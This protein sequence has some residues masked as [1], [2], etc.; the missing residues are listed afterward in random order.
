MNKSRLKAVEGLLL[1][2]ENEQADD[3][4]DAR[5]PVWIIAHVHIRGE[6]DNYNMGTGNDDQ[7]WFVFLG[8]PPGPNSPMWAP[9]V[10]KLAE[11]EDVCVLF[12]P[13]QY[14]FTMANPPCLDTMTC[15]AWED[16]T[17][18]QSLEL[19]R[20]MIAEGALDPAQERDFFSSAHYH[21]HW[22][23]PPYYTEAGL[24]QLA[25]EEAAGGHNEDDR[26]EE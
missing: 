15:C 18:G 2:R 20:E 11:T 9:Q 24:A 3:G 1:A 26:S 23:T 19:V 5:E 6:K 13:H 10:E 25:A 8:Y 14:D 7:E 17:P 22:L 4:E 16:Y 21:W 12:D